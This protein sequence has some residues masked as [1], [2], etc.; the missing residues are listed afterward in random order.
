MSKPAAGGRPGIAPL[1]ARVLPLLVTLAGCMRGAAP[2]AYVAGPALEGPKHRGGRAVFVREEDPDFLD[3][4]LSYGSYTGPVIESVFRTLLDYANAP[5]MAGT[6]LVPELAQS[7]PE[8]REGGTLYCFRVR[9]D[10]RFSPPLRRHIT[11]A[12]FK[13]AM[14]RLYKVGSPGCNFYRG[15]VGVRRVLAGQNSVIPGIIARGDSLYFRLERPDPIFTSVL[16]LPF[17]APVPREVIERHPNDFS[18][19]TVA[20]GPFMITEFIPRRRVVLVRNPDYCGE[21]AWLDTLELRLGVSPLNAVALIRRG[22]ADG[23]F[24]EVPPGDFV[25]L[26]S[27]PYWKNQVMVADGINTEYLFMNAG[28]K[29]FDDVR[30]RQAVNWALDRRAIVKM[31]AGK[32]TVAGEF[33][34]PSMPGYEP[35]ARYQGPDTARARRLLRE[36]GYPQGVDVTL[37][38]WTVEPGPR[39]LALVQQQL[40]DVGIRVR[41]DLGETAGYT[42]MAENVSNHVAFGIYGWY[43]DYVDASNFFDP[44]LNGHRIQAIHN[45][46]LSLFDDS[47]TN[48]MIERAMATPD[49]SARIA[50][51]RKIDRR[52]MDLAPVAPMIHLYESRLYSPRLGGW[53]RHVTRLIKLEQLYL[54]SA[55]REPPVATRGSTRPAHG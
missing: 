22:L 41:L 3:P 5:G 14:E 40:T 34:P 55:P 29:P 23:G 53:Y 32:A 25:R 54:K 27:D 24:F 52:V 33:L 18:Q 39:E 31:Y 36:A 11:A 35:L 38:G 6:R 9:R 44:L 43:A 8:V 30:V 7:L 48:E 45:I 26:E 51:Y 47:K 49:D 4:A 15:I 1:L 37:Y 21:P 28:I 42:S 50:L 19:H 13:Y 12:D 2:P 10:A 20:T 46:N 16:A 17:T